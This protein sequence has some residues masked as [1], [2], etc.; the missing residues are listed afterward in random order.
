[1]TITDHDPTLSTRDGLLAELVAIE[2]EGWEGEQGRHLLAYVLNHVVRPQVIASGLT[3]PAASQAE[4]TGWEVAWEILNRPHLRDLDS[5]WGWVWVAVRRAIQGEVL[6]A[7]YLAGEREAW[8]TRQHRRDSGTE[9]DTPTI[10]LARLMD[11]GWEKSTGQPVRLQLG[12]R[13]MHVV[14]ALAKNGWE[15]RAAHAVVEAVSATATRRT[16]TTA[17]IQGWRSIANELGLPPWQVRRVAVLLLGGPEWPGVVQLMRKSGSQVLA[18]PV[19]VAAVKST[20]NYHLPP[21]LLVARRAAREAA[22][23]LTSVA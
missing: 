23:D 5:P 14:R 1:M 13:L 2:S 17:G 10:S 7:V 3:G 21:P 22:R 20:A 16:T 9:I 12:E 11:L 4:A 15:P 8:R 18:D 19:V 6:S